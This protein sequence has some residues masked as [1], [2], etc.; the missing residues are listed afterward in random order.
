MYIVHQIVHI[1]RTCFV[2]KFD[3]KKNFIKFIGKFHGTAVRN[4]LWE[5]EIDRD[6]SSHASISI[7]PVLVTDL[8]SIL[9]V[10]VREDILFHLTHSRYSSVN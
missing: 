2:W 3:M 1:E 9:S 6:E 10:N 8:I 7:I 5:E 4:S